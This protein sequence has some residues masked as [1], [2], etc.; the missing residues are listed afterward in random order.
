[1]A[2]EY[3]KDYLSEYLIALATDFELQKTVAALRCTDE[4]DNCDGL[5]EYLQ[6]EFHLSGKELDALILAQGKG[7]DSPEYVVLA[8]IAK[9]ASAKWN[10]ST[11][12]SP[13]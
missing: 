8:K 7:E 9:E 6:N 12:V 4:G 1:M 11:V 13:S 10:V 3:E 2:S 5:R